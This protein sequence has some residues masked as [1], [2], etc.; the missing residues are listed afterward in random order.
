[1]FNVFFITNE[2]SL[3]EASPCCYL[4]NLNL[5]QPGS[6]WTEVGAA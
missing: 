5:Q 2:E 4:A 6:E 3:S 1:M